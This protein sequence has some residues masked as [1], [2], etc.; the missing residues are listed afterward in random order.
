MTPIATP[1]VAVPTVSD[2]WLALISRSAAI[3]GRMPWGEYICAKVAV[4][5]AT[6]AMTNRRYS[7][8]FGLKPLLFEVAESLTTYTTVGDDEVRTASD[9]NPE[10]ARL[11]ASSL[12]KVCD[13]YEGHYS[14][15]RFWNQAVAHHEGH[16]KTA[17]ANL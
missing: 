4:P 14:C 16:L 13:C 7:G 3:I 11:V 6:K 15:R 17:D 10:A 12:W 5:A 1:S 2:D 8:D 9:A